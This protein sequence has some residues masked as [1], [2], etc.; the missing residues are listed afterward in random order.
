[1]RKKIIVTLALS[2]GLGSSAA[3]AVAGSGSWSS[4]AKSGDESRAV[5]DFPAAESAYR[6]AL[7]AD[8]PKQEIPRIQVKYTNVLMSQGKF[9]LAAKQLKKTLSSAKS[10][11]GAD[12][13]DYAEGLDLKA[14]MHQVNGK[15]N[16][17]IDSLKQSIA[18]LETKAPGSSDLADALEHMGMLNENVKLYEPAC[19]SY[20][21]ALEIRKKL[22]G[23]NS[24]EVADLYENLGQIAQRRGQRG[25]AL[26]LFAAASRIKESR[27]EPWK[28]FAPE[29]TDRVVIFH[30]IA[31]APWCAE[32]ISEGA[33]I[34][35]VTA[36]GVTVEA[37][38]SQ[39]PSEFAKTTRALV[40]VTNK[41]QYDADLLPQSPT[42]IQITPTVQVLKPLNPQELAQRIEKKGESKA[43]WIK[44]WGAN[45][46]STVSSYGYT[47]GNGVPVYGYVPGSFGWG[48]G[49][50]GIGGYGGYGYSNSNWNRNRYSQTTLMTTQVPDYQKREE[51]YRK[52]EQTTNQ[53]KSDADAIRD[54]ALGPSK[55]MAG[56]GMIQGSLDFEFSKYKKCI[57]RIPIGNSVF[58]F[59]FE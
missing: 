23:E 51:A 30:Y 53:S 43:K 52:A 58:E 57:L 17:A 47:S 12:S 29:P 46:T 39:K 41:S 37:G 32:G 28:P 20:S 56:G 38:I 27:G 34:Q 42:F 22:A 59:R 4:Y 18:L 3:F 15:M 24:V 31:G 6:A 48:G 36:N 13:V 1:M 5:G 7:D 25:E 10:I 35:T 19:D 2:F 40:R 50:G 55:V 9:D 45:A 21:K 49:Y 26:R 16:D 33:V 8:V 11:S 54:A 14:W 44:F